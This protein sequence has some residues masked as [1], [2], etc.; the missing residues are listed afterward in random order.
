MQLV[1]FIKH[2]VLENAFVYAHDVANL[3]E[4]RVMPDFRHHCRREQPSTEET[5]TVH[6]QN[7]DPPPVKFDKYS[8]AD[9][10][11]KLAVIFSWSTEAITGIL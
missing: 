5:A 2:K 8:P 1:T 7:S 3:S 6:D 4:G 9:K 11:Y 10:V